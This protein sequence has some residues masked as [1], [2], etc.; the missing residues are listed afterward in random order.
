[1]RNIQTDYT[2]TVM[3]DQ[4]YLDVEA[5]VTI[6]ADGTYYLDWWDVE[7]AIQQRENIPPKLQEV[8]FELAEDNFR[9]DQRRENVL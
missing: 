2:T 7:G 8:L 4:E 5:Q 3:I 6:S 1:M 9:A